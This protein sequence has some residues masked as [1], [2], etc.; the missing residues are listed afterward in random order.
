M[1]KKLLVFSLIVL[2]LMGLMAFARVGDVITKPGEKEQE[3]AQLKKQSYVNPRV[4]KIAVPDNRTVPI[5]VKKLGEPVEEITTA[6]PIDPEGDVIPASVKRAKKPALLKKHGYLYPGDS[7]I[8][9]LEKTT[10]NANIYPAGDIN[11]DGVVNI[12][13]AKIL[14]EFISN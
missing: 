5:S 12:D 1:T 9:P 14:I 3:I 8:V 10:E 4:S 2:F 11:A 13:D 6:I 7:Q